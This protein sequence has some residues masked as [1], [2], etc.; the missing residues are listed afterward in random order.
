MSLRYAIRSDAIEVQGVGRFTDNHRR[1]VA[2]APFS[3]QILAALVDEFDVSHDEQGRPGFRLYK[4][5]N[6]E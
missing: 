1:A 4:R 6:H 5:R 2:L 3:E